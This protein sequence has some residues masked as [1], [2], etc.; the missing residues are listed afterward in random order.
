MGQIWGLGKDWRMR[1]L[2]LKAWSTFVSL[3]SEVCRFSTTQ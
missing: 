2:A 3:V 1:I